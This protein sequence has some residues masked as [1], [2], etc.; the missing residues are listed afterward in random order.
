ML[1]ERQGKSGYKQSVEAIR[2]EL[3]LRE[4]ERAAEVR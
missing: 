1:N 2:E 3:R 4:Q